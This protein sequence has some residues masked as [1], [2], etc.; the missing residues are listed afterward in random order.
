M[1]DQHGETKM[2]PLLV[3]SGR[4][5][6]HLKYYFNSIQLSHL[7]W[8]R[9]ETAE[10]LNQCLAKSSFV[11]LAIS[12]D[13]IERF[14]LDHL[15]KTRLTVVHFS[16]ALFHPEILSFHPLMTFTHHLYDLDFYKKIHFAVSS[17]DQFKKLLPQL[18]NPCF[19]LSDS[20]KGFYHAWA[21]MMASGSQSFWKYAIKQMKTIGVPEQACE[22]YLK[23]MAAQFFLDKKN[24]MTGPWIRNDQ[25]TIEKN[26]VSLNTIEDRK[27]YDLLQS[28]A[29]KDQT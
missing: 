12:D 15:S 26:K 8:S 14:Y 20:Q 29:K 13:A 3:G 11:M 18:S 23:Q 17:L 21:V 6:S 24:S 7:T 19:Q 2:Q 5:A 1:I 16:G 9:S 27:L 25:K 10:V 4:L 28:L 22:I